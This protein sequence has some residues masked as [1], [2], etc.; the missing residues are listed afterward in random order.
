[1]KEAV[2]VSA[3]RSPVGKLGGGLAPLQPYQ[4][5]AL[6][7]REA[8]KRANI[9][10]AQVD[11]VIY[12]TVG[13]K[14]MN[15]AARVVALESGLPVEVPAIALDRQCGTSLNALAYGAILIQAG[16]HDVVVTGG[17]EMDSR[18]PWIMERATKAYGNTPPKFYPPFFAPP[19]FGDVHVLT[20]AENVAERY[21]LTREMCDRFAMDSQAKAA[22]AWNE[23]KFADEILPIDVTEKRGTRRV[24]RDETVRPTTMEALAKLRVATGKKDGVVTAG[25]SSPNCDGASCVVLMEKNKAKELGIDILAT[26]RGYASVGLDPA[27]MGLGPAFAIPKLL[28]TTGMSIE[29]IDLFE[30]NEAFA[31]QS[32]ACIR[33][34]QLDTAKLN[35]NGG[36][37]ALGH[38][39]GATGGILTAKMVYELKRRQAR[40]GVI[41]FC[42]GGGQGV[43]A[44][45]ERGDA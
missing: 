16:V 3:V 1:M 12:G 11:E 7:M 8:I 42:C 20:T 17:V 14:E 6:V 33:E 23:G 5:G 2:I 25:N 34:L 24:E 4:L 40:F 13:N 18:R 15:D 19:S 45:L 22:Q 30:I 41:A 39:L 37:I 26:F 44:L 27:Y 21:G 43:A 36:A 28:K 38:P 35:V 9:A 10:P 32:L 31:S 29:H